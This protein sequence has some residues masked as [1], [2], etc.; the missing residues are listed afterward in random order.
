MFYRIIIVFISALL[1]L[2]IN[3]V[4]AKDIS[5][6]NIDNYMNKISR[7]FSRTYC[8]T[9]KFGISDQ[10]ALAFAIG[11]TNKEFKKNKLNKLIDYSMLF[12][13]ITL[14]LEN[15]CQAYDFPSSKLA[16]LKFDY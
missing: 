13:K 16:E 10:G 3:P 15:D 14:N 9:S 4:F 7:K 11:E 6:K 5:N 2:I 8:N 12:D 1:F